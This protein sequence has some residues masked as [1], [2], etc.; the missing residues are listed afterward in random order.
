[1][2][3][4]KLTDFR[5]QRANANAHTPQGMKAL[6]TS[7]QVDGWIGAITVAA[8]GETFDGSAR[9]E[10]GAATGFEDA[11]VVESDGTRP[12]I[13]MRTDIPTAD[14]PRARRLGIM[15]N[16]VA[17]LNLSWDAAQLEDALR[18][19]E[20]DNPTMAALLDDL[21][22]AAGIVPPDFAP[23]GIEEQGRLDEKAKCTCPEC[24]HVFTP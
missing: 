16:R 19:I 6:E 4:R 2:T 14:D 9:I 10:T 12:V 15:A 5:P 24:G 11:I 17:E 13:V 21:A 22:T 20:T 7:I 1:M 8:D 23:V 3:K 18:S